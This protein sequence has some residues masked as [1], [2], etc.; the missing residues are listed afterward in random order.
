[1]RI[2][3]AIS[4]LQRGGAERVATLLANAWSAQGH[5]VSLVTFEAEGAQP[6]Y[7]LSANVE[8]TQLGL[9]ASSSSALDG[10]LSNV[11]RIRS[12]RR[13]L[14]R[15]EPDVVVSFLTETNVL[16]VAAGL[17]AS[18]PTLVSE[19]VHPAYHFVSRPWRVLRRA[20]YPRAAGIVV[21]GLDIARWVKS[22]IGAD[23]V[24]I[25]N[26]VDTAVFFPNPSR[27][28]RLNRRKLL[29]AA[30]RLSPQKGFDTLIHEF[31]AAA[32]SLP[33][34]DLAI[35]GDGP[36][37]SLLR[38]LIT[39]R[40]LTGRVSINKS[41]PDIADVYRAATAFVHS[42]RYEGYPNVIVEA[43]ASGLPVIASD[44]QDVVR[45]ILADG[46]YGVLYK[47]EQPGAL[48][49]ALI[50][51]LQDDARCEALA[52]AAPEA[53]KEIGVDTISRRWIDLFEAAVARPELPR[54]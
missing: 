38:A 19:R 35:Y 15:I 8:L 36:Q 41:V 20:L 32:S 52:K 47:A 14:R 28:F 3:F 46:K 48:A 13:C 11:M 42:A 23:A 25:P 51:T 9:S 43:L 50:V 26:P 53:V 1:M 6:A 29:L 34:W 44:S 4:S 12:L 17:G 24:V 54:V 37:E 18:W 21:Q 10:M 5:S 30:G 39:D 7:P 2:A 49:Q 16:A 31:S 22:H 33:E 45:A 40:G 27:D